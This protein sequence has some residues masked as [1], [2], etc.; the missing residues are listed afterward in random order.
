MRKWTYLVAMLMLTCAT[1]TFTG[2]IDTDEPQ[3]ITELRGAKAKL[4]EAKA[5][6]EAAKV[7]QVNAE[8]KLKEAE[9]KAKE[10]EAQATILRAEYEKAI[11]EAQSAAYIKQIE[12]EIAKLQ[13]ET[14]AKLAEAEA[15]RQEVINAQKLAAVQLQIAAA[16][17]AGAQQQALQ[18][19]ITAYEQA[20]TAYDQK[21]IDYTNA[22]NA[23][24]AAVTNLETNTQSEIANKLD[25]E[26]ALEDAKIAKA[27]AEDAIQIYTD[28]LELA[29]N[30]TP[31]EL[32]AKR[33]AYLAEYNSYNDSLVLLQLELDKLPID[34]PEFKK[35][36]ELRK[37]VTEA[38]KYTIEEYKNDTA[39]GNVALNTVL[40]SRLTAADG[41]DNGV[42]SYQKNENAALQYD[43]N[44]ELIPSTE[45][46]MVEKWLDA[47]TAAYGTKNDQINDSIA[48]ITDQYSKAVDEKDSL[49]QVA[50]AAWE[51]LVKARYGEKTTAQ[52]AIDTLKKYTDAYNATFAKLAPAITAYNSAIDNLKS[53]EDAVAVAAYNAE[54]AVKEDSVKA[55]LYVKIFDMKY[56]S[57]ILGVY[58][59][60]WNALNNK[61]TKKVLDFY[62]SDLDSTKVQTFLADSVAKAWAKDWKTTS[63]DYVEKIIAPATLK[64]NNAIAADMQD[65][66]KGKIKPAIN[67][68]NAAWAKADSIGNTALSAN[69]TAVSTK[70][71]EF[72]AILAND[73]GQ[74][75]S[76]KQTDTSMKLDYTNPWKNVYTDK[77]APLTDTLKVYTSAADAT[78]SYYY[79]AA[80]GSD[81]DATEFT[82]MT[83]SELDEATV[84]SK[85]ADKSLA[86]WGVNDRMLPITEEEAEEMTLA[87]S[88]FTELLDAKA[89]LAEFEAG[90]GIYDTLAMLIEQITAQKD[91]LDAQVLEVEESVADKIAARDEQ[92]AV[93][94]GLKKEI[95]AQ[96]KAI[97]N[98]QGIANE[99]YQAYNDACNNFTGDMLD[100]TAID[101]LITRLE[102]LLTAAKAVN[103]E[104]LELDIRV[105]EEALANWDAVEQAAV[106]SAE[107]SMNNAK[108][109]MDQA[110]AAMDRAE[111]RLTAAL[112]ALKNATAAE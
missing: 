85:W 49:H 90:M 18:P 99:F 108:Y 33:D 16:Q 25:L 26:I 40:A 109:Y 95:K 28:S 69:W 57:S 89:A 52:A 74:I 13:A 50:V 35:L 23:Y 101:T 59:A 43:A 47:L 71:G 42:F 100:Q 39:K 17:L 48:K 12:A 24:N 62:L 76:S 51:I 103:F 104:Q 5:L 79:V 15:T 45:Y 27:N 94:Q 11:A 88:T 112:E 65:T 7:A 29:K 41:Y 111:E 38:S 66:K 64:K 9:A 20:V 4:L 68:V 102:G 2:C 32:P 55:D 10:A 83:A 1:T 22:L 60:A 34:N 56:D 107:I 58:E 78:L 61:K 93:V 91:A 19:Y 97:E 75:L 63:T 80:D 73:F 14:E 96:I 37:A 106:L 72:E 92:K 6:V 36:A 67:A 31:D 46:A 8:A 21:Y 81:I 86:A 54:I 30:M 82:K 70:Y 98:K 84:N 77:V 105:A 87:T 53:V 44:D 3:G 110:K